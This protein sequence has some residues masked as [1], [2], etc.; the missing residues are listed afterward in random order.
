MLTSI[1]GFVFWFASLFFAVRFM[2]RR[3]YGLAYFPML[4][5]VGLY[6]IIRKLCP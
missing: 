6:F 4:A 5:M 3:Q 1:A 2:R